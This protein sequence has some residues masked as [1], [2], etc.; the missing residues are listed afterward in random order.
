MALERHLDGHI[1]HV[2]ID[3]LQDIFTSSGNCE[4]TNVQVLN[5]IQDGFFLFSALLLYAHIAM[6]FM[7]GWM[8]GSK[9]G[10]HVW[11]TGVASRTCIVLADFVVS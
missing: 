1:F 8:D 4:A 5:C 10:L 6:G 3:F 11:T 7:D 9:S 2:D